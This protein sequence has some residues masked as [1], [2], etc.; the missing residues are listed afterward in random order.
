MTRSLDPL[1]AQ[2]SRGRERDLDGLL[3]MDLASG[4][5][6]AALLWS[7]AGIDMV[8][9]SVS[10]ALQVKR[11]DHRTSDVVAKSA[12]ATLLIESKLGG[13]QYELGQAE[14]YR[15]ECEATGARALTIAP[16]TFEACFR[17]AQQCFNGFVAVEKLAECLRSAAMKTASEEL[18]TAYLHRAACYQQLTQSQQPPAIEDVVDFGNLYRARAEQRTGGR[19]RVTDTSFRRGQRA[20]FVKGAPIPAPYRA[21]HKTRHRVLD[22]IMVDWTF[23]ALETCWQAVQEKPTGWYVAEQAQGTPSDVTDEPNPVL[24]YETMVDIEISTEGFYAARETIDTVIRALDDMGG[25][26]RR[27][28]HPDDRPQPKRILDDLLNRAAHLAASAD[29]ARA[30]AIRALVPQA[31]S[32]V[33]A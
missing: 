24:R 19:V 9:E 22:I 30:A 12:G 32:P 3:A 4:S 27:H 8:P 5:P 17:T 7:T 18:C 6:V 16:A 1:T 21:M 11:G 23:D 10:V 2:A 31:P 20:E 26:I 14:S 13:G 29:P 15:A 25:W 28:M 33:D